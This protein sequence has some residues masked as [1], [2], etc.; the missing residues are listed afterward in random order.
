MISWNIIHKDREIE[1]D[2]NHRIRVGQMK[3]RSLLRVLC[4]CWLLINLK[5]ILKW[6]FENTHKD[7]IQNEEI[8]LKIV[9]APIDE[10]IVGVT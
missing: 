6:I 5:G 8:H 10:K 1:N 3:W 7:R 2:V 4:N 9:M